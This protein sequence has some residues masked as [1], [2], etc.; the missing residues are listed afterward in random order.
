MTVTIMVSVITKRHKPEVR[1]ALV[2]QEFLVRIYGRKRTVNDYRNLENCKFINC[3][4]RYE[5]V[6]F[7]NI[8][9]SHMTGCKH[10]VRRD[11][12]MRHI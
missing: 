8:F 11:I 3:I 4:S 6:L 5:K 1:I 12:F 7:I 10:C 2:V 9:Y